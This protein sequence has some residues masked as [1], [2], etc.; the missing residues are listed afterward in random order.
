MAIIFLYFSVDTSYVLSAA[1]ISEPQEDVLLQDNP[2][3][4]AEMDDSE[5][6]S[7]HEAADNTSISVSDYSD[8]KP[9]GYAV[10]VESS[11]ASIVTSENSEKE[12]TSCDIPPPLSSVAVSELTEGQQ[13]QESPLVQTVINNSS[14]EEESDKITA[15]CAAELST[16][17][18][19]LRTMYR[20]ELCAK[21][22]SNTANLE[23]HKN[24]H[25]TNICIGSDDEL[26]VDASFTSTNDAD[27]D[28]H[29]D[30]SDNGS[31]FLKDE[32]TSE[33]EEV[34]ATGSIK[35]ETNFGGN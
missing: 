2:E 7:V 4:C 29:S 10:M 17:V 21:T 6:F 35:E 16:N 30:E 9:G 14:L 31:V 1:G 24:V 15:D 25:I 28:T 13:V 27:D 22:F 3:C 23:S 32:S 19:C 18:R 8:P 12:H 20:C 5:M 33:E 26:E 34:D 11:L